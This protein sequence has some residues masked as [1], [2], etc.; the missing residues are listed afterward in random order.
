MGSAEAIKP[1][2]QKPLNQRWLFTEIDSS[3]AAE[4]ARS[5][6]LPLLI[7]ELLVTRGVATAQQAAEFLNP[8]IAHLT[9][10]YA[11]SGMRAAVE[12]LQKAIREQEPILIYGDY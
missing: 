12:R 11:M 8:E 2:K 7:A 1:S 3:K 6:Q 9:D 5:A 10:P 4:L